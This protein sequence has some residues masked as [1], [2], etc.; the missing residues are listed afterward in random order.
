MTGGNSVRSNNRNDAIQGLRAIAALLVVV[1]HSILNLLERTYSDPS[2]LQL[3]YRFGEVGVRIFFVISGFIMTTTM[4]GSFGVPGA[5]AGFILKRLWRIV[6]IYWLATLIYA[7]KLCLTG[8][9]PRWDDLLLSLF[10]IP[11]DHGQPMGEP[12][13]GLGWTLNFEM[14]FY[15]L[16]AL[17]LLLRRVAAIVLLL[18][19]LAGLV[20]FGFVHDLGTCSG[21]FCMTAVY[22]TR[23]LL[24]YF[25]A[26][27]LLGLYRKW[28]ENRGRPLQIH[29]YTAVGISLVVLLLYG[30]MVLVGLIRNDSI[31]SDIAQIFVC[32]L[33]TTVCALEVHTVGSRARYRVL[34]LAL[35]DASY[36]IYLTH[37]FLTGSAARIWSRISHGSGSPESVALF[38]VLMIVGASIVG[39][40]T[41]R[42]I[43]K[44]LLRFSRSRLTGTRQAVA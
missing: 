41:Y 16:F 2:L 43:E 9:A 14:F 13:Y 7:A 3:A 21:P 29:T 42:F 8:H 34:L 30:L 37:S 1:D 36:S 12:V 11:Y 17:A 33:A 15:Y 40:L 38:V 39:L 10:F 20:A 22:Y 18:V 44:P 25:A 27:I 23:P 28:V 35:G 19:V 6:P 24:L 32:I 31:F 4:Y 5:S 26:G